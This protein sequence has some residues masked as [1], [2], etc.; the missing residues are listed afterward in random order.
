MS[1][2]E[3]KKIKEILTSFLSNNKGYLKVSPSKIAFDKFKKLGIQYTVGQDWLD[4]R[5]LVKEV[6]KELRKELKTIDK[7]IIFGKEGVICKKGGF[8]HQ[9]LSSEIINLN[10]APIELQ[11]NPK[12][13]A[14]KP[15]VKRLFYDIETSANVVF[16]W[17]IGNRIS[18]GMD[19]I[20]EERKIICIG[21]K[22]EH[23]SEVHC[24]NFNISNQNEKEMLQKFAKVI[25]SADEIC[26]HN[27]DNF[28]TKHL[29]ARCIYYGI[30]LNPKFNSIDTL[31]E[32]RKQ[33]KF[34]S[35]KLNYIAQFLG[36]GKKIDTEFGLWKD[37]ILKKDKG[38]LNKMIQ[39]CK[40]DVELTEQVYH[41]LEPFTIGKKYKYV[42]R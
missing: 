25:N 30:Q 22:W 7:G 12:D 24:L 37:I 26:G 32:S 3:K 13:V 8:V 17:N 11:Y 38:A 15:K 18:I 4:K 31:K 42:K 10:T 28:D 16:S 21:Y 6:Q 35:N 14:F 40:H 39:Y 1:N 41:K 36:L 19:N 34:N 29:R 5:D 20:I 2:K 27:I 33:F 23:E 9:L